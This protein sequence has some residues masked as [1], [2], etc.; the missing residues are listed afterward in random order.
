M[1]NLTMTDPKQS[2]EMTPAGTL[3][4][5]DDLALA[6]RMLDALKSG[7]DVRHRKV[8]RVRAAIRALAYENPLKLHVALDRLKEEIR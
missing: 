4:S 8:R 3:P 7:S 6:S 5:E 2:T 1:D